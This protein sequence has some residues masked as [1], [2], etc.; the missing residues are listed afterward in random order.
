MAKTCIRYSIEIEK[1]EKIFTTFYEI[2]KAKHNDK[3]FLS[4]IEEFIVKGLLVSR[5]SEIVV[6][7]NQ[8]IEKIIN[9][10]FEQYDRRN[11]SALEHL[12]L[13]LEYNDHI[14]TKE[15]SNPDFCK[16]LIEKCKQYRL[17]KAMAHIY[18][19]GLGD[20]VTPVK[21]IL[22]IIFDPSNNNASDRP[23][24]VTLLFD[25]LENCFLNAMSISNQRIST[26]LLYD[27]KLTLL[28]TVVQ[29]TTVSQYSTKRFHTLSRLIILDSKRFF[30]WLDDVFSDTST[31]SLWTS[32]QQ[33]TQPSH[34]L[35]APLTKQSVVDALTYIFC[36]S[37]SHAFSPWEIRTKKFSIEEEQQPQSNWIPNLEDCVYFSLFMA[38]QLSHSS[39]QFPDRNSI[40]V[41][42]DVIHRIFS[43]LC[44]EG[45]LFDDDIS[46]TQLELVAILTNILNIIDRKDSKAVI[47]MEELITCCRNSRFH[48]V[49][50]YLYSLKGDYEKL[51]DAYLSDND[52]RS[53][54]F[55]FINNLTKL[56]SNIVNREISE[57]FQINEKTILNKD[58]IYARI[59][60]ATINHLSQLIECDSDATAHLIIMHFTSEHE[61]VI[62][63][64]NKY[65]KLQF[66]YLKNIIG[67]ENT[68][69]SMHELLKRKGLTLDR[70]VHL[71]Y[72]QLLCEFEPQSV[73][74][75][76]AS[77]RDYPI[78][79]CLKF[80]RQHNI[81]DATSYLLER[82][83][84][85]VGAVKLYLEKVDEKM[86]SLAEQ[87]VSEED[88]FIRS[89]NFNDFLA[90]TNNSE[91][92]SADDEGINGPPLSDLFYLLKEF[93]GKYKTFLQIK[94][95][96]EQ[97]QRKLKLS[98]V[99]DPKV[100]KEEEKFELKSW[101]NKMLSVVT[102][103]AKS[104]ASEMHETSATQEMT[105]MITNPESLS[106]G[107]RR[108]LEVQ[109][110]SSSVMNILQ[111]ETYEKFKSLI[112]D[113]VNMC[114]R[115]MDNGRLT[116]K[117]V[118]ILWFHLLD[119]IIVPLRELFDSYAA[120][121]Q[122]NASS[123]ITA[124]A[125]NHSSSKS[126]ESIPSTQKKK[127]KSSNSDDD[128]DN[129]SND[130]EID[131][132][133]TF[134][135]DLSDDEDITIED[136]INDHK[137]MINSAIREKEKLQEKVRYEF[138]PVVTKTTYEKIAKIE[139]RITS[140]KKY[141]ADLEY[142]KAREEERKLR[143]AT[144]PLAPKNLKNRPSNLFFQVCL[145]HLLKFIFT[146]M[147][148][149][150]SSI[151]D[152]EQ[153]DPHMSMNA[154]K[155][156]EKKFSVFGLLQSATINYKKDLYGYFKEP[157]L[158]MYDK[159]GFELML[160]HSINRLLCNDVNWLQNRYIRRLKRGTKPQSYTCRLCESSIYDLQ[161]DNMK[162]GKLR[163]FY[164]G[165]AMHEHCLDEIN[166]ISHC[167]I[168][169]HQDGASDTTTDTMKQKNTIEK[170]KSMSGSSLL[171]NYSLEADVN[172]GQVF[173]SVY[174]KQRLRM[175]ENSL[176]NALKAR[177]KLFD[178]LDKTN[179]K[180]VTV[181]EHQGST[182]HNDETPQQ[183]QQSIENSSREQLPCSEESSTTPIVAAGQ[184]TRT[185]VDY[186]KTEQPLKALRYGS[187]SKA[188]V[189]Y[190]TILKRQRLV[191]E[192]KVDEDYEATKVSKPRNNAAMKQSQPSVKKTLKLDLPKKS[193]STKDEVKCQYIPP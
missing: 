135:D 23:Q 116:D 103:F 89:I 104:S 96:E 99:V 73:Y 182:S 78:D 61:K 19:K 51:L 91:N 71:K 54:V 7:P 158:D 16:K 65:P 146:E 172:S 102:A 137:E 139:K 100:K 189:S 155:K 143:E 124:V 118:K 58:Q 38:K 165:H 130:D 98:T 74:T 4:I 187:Y 157:L 11:L 159:C 93:D 3:L 176:A 115:N 56:E 149:S 29:E 129:D 163:V 188:Q 63:S 25:Y 9:H 80:C 110:Y 123:T 134:M 97:Q 131:N 125:T 53:G 112:T 32:E 37:S 107:K 76:V 117:D 164:C 105:S 1:S 147:S 44:Y 132:D 148:N 126:N 43:T 166:C 84:D 45:N 145:H 119:K 82:G 144:D 26:S 88:R 142:E 6:I 156:F 140:L 41:S 186:V 185:L 20:F 175:V 173:V 33:G 81:I 79:E 8:F 40:R 17:F 128:E 5:E 154:E 36:S 64:L 50:S 122:N 179:D 22:K 30:K 77:Q 161:E 101:A 55:T 86:R 42:T 59:K 141:L 14:S 136:N 191:D 167:P 150:S 178:E 183:E 85:V 27:I 15:Y 192:I 35:Y 31:T 68:S 153:Q 108:L 21:E 190:S 184:K 13:S 24:C 113:I 193:T 28:N 87:C 169:S 152:E 180:T 18:N 127:K 114:K 133:M 170:K 57:L 160:Y 10:H 34:P 2:F 90:V 109:L 60:T 48:K 70:N 111:S 12:L 138:D 72:F 174:K 106:R 66:L 75:Y 49:L 177:R 47:N 94:W 69:D 95:E 62:S 171:H 168:C 92:N 162:G 151:Q 181:S 120:A 121:S 67:V 39:Q 83:G 52:L 46:T